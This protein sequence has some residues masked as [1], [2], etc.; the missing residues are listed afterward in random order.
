MRIPLT[1]YGM[2][3]VAFYPAITGLLM[4]LF[5]CL[6]LPGGVVVVIEVL[7]GAV[8]AWM[9]SFF[10]DPHRVIPMDKNVLISPADG[11]VTD[12]EYYEDRNAIGGKAIKIGIFLSVFNVHINRAP[13][14]AR[15]ERI[16]YKK[17]KFINALDPACGKVNEANNIFMTR[18]DEPMGK[19]VV[20]Q[21]SGAIA[22]HIVCD[23]EEGQV[24]QRGQQFGMIKF[25]SCTELHFPDTG[26]ARILVEKGD[27]VRAGSTIMVRFE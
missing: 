26:T 11:T 8:L 16:E 24:L 22:R 19:I 3:Q 15:V 10:R 2:P 18:L 27:K 4:L 14:A 20:R 23:L 9:L 5:L 1:K 21:V 25:G 13:C 6:P 12:V 7:L 17:G